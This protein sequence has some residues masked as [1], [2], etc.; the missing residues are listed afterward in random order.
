MR[1]FAVSGHSGMGK[2][3]VVEKIVEA[4]S[5]RGYTVVTVK[6]SIHVLKREDGTD[7]WRHGQAGAKTTIVLGPSSTLIQYPERKALREILNGDEADFLIIEGMKGSEIPKFWCIGASRIDY[8]AIPK[9]VKAI[10]TW[11]SSIME[12]EREI[13]IIESSDIERLVS[14]V[15]QEAVELSELD[16]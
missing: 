12:Q 10:V 14:V 2:T 9:S 15:K 5:S 4:L 11:D 8:A 1:V 3:T 7:S 6:N 13:P 16:I